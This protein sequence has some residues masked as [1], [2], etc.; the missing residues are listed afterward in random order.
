MKLSKLGVQILSIFKM[1]IAIIGGGAAGFFAA[2]SAKEFHPDGEI[3]LIEK[4]GKLLQKVLVS[5]GG[6]CNVTHACLD[7]DELIR[8]YPRGSKELRQAFRQFSVK[9]TLAWFKHRNVELKTEA[10][11]RMFPV[12]N[13]SKTIADCLLNEANNRGV[14]VQMNRQIKSISSSQYEVTLLFENER[15]ETFH[16]VIIAT[17]G[18]S[19]LADYDWLSPLGHTI[20]PPVP[21]LF[22]F[23]LPESPLISM[24]GISVQD[25]EIS[26]PKTKF[27]YKGILLCTHWGIS[28]PV[29]LKLSAFAARWMH[30]CGYKFNLKVR[31]LGDS[32]LIEI[33]EKLRNIAF[34]SPRKLIHKQA[35][36]DFPLRFWQYSLDGAGIK[37]DRVWA[38][39]SKK[40]FTRL[41]EKLYADILEVNG[42]SAFKEEFVTAGGI[43]LKEI[44]F[45]TM[46]S[47]LHPNISFAGEVLDVDGVTGGFNF[48]AAW[49][50]GWLAGKHSSTNFSKI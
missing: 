28:G 2:I 13:S 14:V 45:A 48:Q 49:T 11:G 41:S 4:S 46:K 1:R 8:N 9:D 19:K 7:D 23:H 37:E 34:Q 5:G 33:E 43:S 22:T 27:Y 25:V 18:R 24:P 12:S 29:V 16:H 47:K 31:W 36:F 6:R 38:E 20:V 44:D 42:R 39:I 21:S 17:G 10:D 3:F 35:S 30:E 50:S 15:E 40:E 26:I 32:S